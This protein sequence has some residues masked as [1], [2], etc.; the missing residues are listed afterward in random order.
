MSAFIFWVKQ[1][2][3]VRYLWWVVRNL[4]P[5]FVFLLFWPEISGFLARFGWFDVCM[6]ALRRFWWDLNMNPLFIDATGW[7]RE[8]WAWA[9]DF[10]SPLLGV[11]R[12]LAGTV[13]GWLPLPI[14]E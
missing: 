13:I 10:A 9:V 8:G 7:L 2:V 6:D 5:F 4:W 3:V 11:I 12:D 1:A 14:G